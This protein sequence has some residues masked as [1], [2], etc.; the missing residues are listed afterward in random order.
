MVQCGRPL[1]CRTSSCGASFVWPDTATNWM[2][3]NSSTAVDQGPPLIW[4][5]CPG[6]TDL[7]NN[8]KPVKARRKGQAPLLPCRRAPSA[9][10][11]PHLIAG[12]QPHRHAATHA[13][14]CPRR[15]TGQLPNKSPGLSRDLAAG[16]ARHDPVVMTPTTGSTNRSI[17]SN[18][19]RRTGAKE[20]R[21]PRGRSGSG[22][23]TNLQAR[24]A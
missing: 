15:R 14:Q 11:A 13:V 18:S 12:H 6:A 1:S 21:Q 20:P 19:P 8:G 23:G 9:S 2:S 16:K 4:S 7:N 5:S 24:R 17:T 3:T 10:S 22:P